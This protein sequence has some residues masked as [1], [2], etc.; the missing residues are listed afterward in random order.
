[1]PRIKVSEL[2]DGMVLDS[3]VPGKDGKT[4]IPAGSVVSGKHQVVLKAAQ[5]RYVDIT[6]ESAALA[7]MLYQE[8]YDLAVT[9][10]RTASG[11]YH[12]VRAEPKAS[13]GAA[14]DADGKNDPADTVVVQRRLVMLASMFGEYRD[15]PVMRQLCRLAITCAKEGLIGV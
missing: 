3:D 6:D 2:K 9:A 11:R 1:M 13:A 5:V 12:V 10:R 8:D 4:L 7:E 15:D 14:D